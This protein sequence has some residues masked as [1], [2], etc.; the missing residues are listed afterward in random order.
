VT[1]D[2]RGYELEV[3]ER[4]DGPEL[5]D[6]LWLRHY[7]PHWSTR[8]ASR[9]RFD[10]GVGELRLRIDADQPPWNP[11]HDGW[12][13]ASGLQTGQFSGPLGSGMGQLKFTDGLTVREE[14]PTQALYTPRHGL[15]EIRLRAVADPANM[16]ALWMIGFEDVPERSGEILVCEIFGRDMTETSAR[17]GM[18]VR[19]WA[20]PSL[21]DHFEEVALEIDARE[22]HWYAVTW[23][24]DRV[25]FYV[26]E[27]RVKTVEQAPDYPMQFMLSFY[28]FA[29]GPAPASPPDRYPKTAV[30]ERFRGWRPVTGESARPAAFP[31]A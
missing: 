22:P 19:P 31:T 9:A 21:D 27:R 3:D 20:D 10:V 28:E 1:L 5:D 7:L 17:I 13:R 23:T 6:R 2:R 18:G 29:E 4:F 14:Q 8:E 26:D 12:L 11:E 30:V 25:D 15:F 24:P 16:V